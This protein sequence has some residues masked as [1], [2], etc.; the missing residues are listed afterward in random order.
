MPGRH[1]RAQPVDCEQVIAFHSR[2]SALITEESGDHLRQQDWP[3]TGDDRL[4]MGRAII[5][6]ALEIMSRPCTH[7][8]PDLWYAS[9]EQAYVEAVE[10]AIFGY[11]RLQT[12]LE[13][14]AVEYVESHDCDSAV[15]RTM[16]IK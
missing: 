13:M 12:L 14:P 9:Q 6:R 4:L 5:A 15:R 3:V 2:A 7:D 16:P 10:N 11:G 1:F 8:G